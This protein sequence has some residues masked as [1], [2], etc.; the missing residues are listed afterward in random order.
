MQIPTIHTDRLSLVPPSGEAGQL[1]EDFYTDAQASAAYG[2][3]LTP[4]AASARLASDRMNWDVGGFGI[5]VIQRRQ[6][7]DLVGVCGYWQ[8]KGWPRELTWW[9]LP[10]ARGAGI[11]YEAS[12]AVVRHAYLQFRW[13]VVETYMNDTNASA[14]SLALRLGGI[15]TDRRQFPDGMERDVFQIPKPTDA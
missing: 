13:P 10:R 1:Y 6:E 15:K 8:G 12:R 7:Q 9:L 4:A 5:W 2:G 14:R 3:P 11:A